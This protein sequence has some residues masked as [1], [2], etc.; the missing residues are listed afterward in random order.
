MGRVIVQSGIG[1]MSIRRGAI[2]SD[3]ALDSLNAYDGRIGGE[4]GGRRDPL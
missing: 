2:F 3:T 4:D 1:C